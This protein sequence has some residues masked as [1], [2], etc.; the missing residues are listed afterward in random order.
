MLN[1]VKK[2]IGKELRERRF[3]DLKSRISI[4]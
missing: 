1:S 2:E 4:L 3:D